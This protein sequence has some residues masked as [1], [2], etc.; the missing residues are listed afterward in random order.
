MRR[1]WPWLIIPILIW[2]AQ[3]NPTESVART[4][5]ADGFDFPVGKPDAEGYYKARGFRPNGHLGEDWNGVGGGNTDLGDPV[6]SAAHGIVVFARDVK[7]GWGNVVIVR[8][9][10]LE[11]GELKTV[12]SLYGHLDKI[13][14]KENQ[15]VLRGQLVGTI[16]TNRGMYPAHL[17]FEMRKNLFIGVNRTAFKGDF[18][19]YYSPTDFINPRRKLPG[20]GRS[21]M[22]AMNTFKDPRTF[23]PPSQ[24]SAVTKLER[25]DGGSARQQPTTNKNRSNS[26]QVNRYGD[27][28]SL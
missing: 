27:L 22:V 8:H 10:Y 19:N 4:R 13:T 9:I 7:L 26:F 14:V 6:Y 11:K 23:G 5:V 3:G 12:D 16:G 28:E 15:Q 25:T 21:A 18:S 1:L 2:V 20:S 24:G 17:H